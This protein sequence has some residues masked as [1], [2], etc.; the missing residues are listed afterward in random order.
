MHQENQRL[1]GNAVVERFMDRC[2]KF[3]HTS[4][5]SDKLICNGFRRCRVWQV[6]CFGRL[7]G[8]G[9]V[10]ST[11]DPRL[12]SLLRHRSPRWPKRVCSFPTFRRDALV[13][14]GV[15]LDRLAEI[16]L[17]DYTKAGVLTPE[18][19]SNREPHVRFTN[20]F[21]ASLFF[22]ANKTSWQ[23]VG[24][25]HVGSSRPKNHVP[26]CIVN[27]CVVRQA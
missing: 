21:T 18:D 4:S 11:S 6:A 25:A 7:G 17:I 10:S 24:R 26:Q 27:L 13:S 1:T 5:G 9:R 19:D 8:F 22:R 3:V 2:V 23:S 12:R 14:C 15:D 16:F 20:S